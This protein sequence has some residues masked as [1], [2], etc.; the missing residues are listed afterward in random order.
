MREQPGDG[1]LRESI[2]RALH[3]MADKEQ[4]QSRVSIQQ[5]LRGGRARLRRRRLMR[6][7]GV[8]VLAATAVSAIAVGSIS[9]PAGS[10]PNV[11]YGV[12]ALKPRA[13][14]VVGPCA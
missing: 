9:L 8:P 12:S 5:A 6:A 14:V 3:E 10:Q 13:V 11:A 1:V 7:A 2:G 4:P